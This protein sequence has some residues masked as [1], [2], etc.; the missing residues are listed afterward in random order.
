MPTYDPL[1]SGDTLT[2]LTQ[3]FTSKNVLGA[4]NSTLQ[5]N[6]GYTL[7]DGNGGANYTVTTN[8]VPGTITPAP[9]TVSTSAVNRVYDGT[10]NAAGSA[11]VTGG[12]L[13]GGDTLTGGTFAFVSKN[14]GTN[15][16]VN[17]SGVS[18]N[19][20]NGGANYVV[21][22][23]SNNTSNI[24]QANLNITGV[25]TANRTYDATTVASLGGSATV[26][27]FG[28]DVVSVSGTGTGSFAN[29]NV[30][31]A[32]AVT[33]TGFGLTGADAGNYLV[34][35]PTGLTA[36]ITQANLNIT[37]VTTANRTY[38]ATTV[39]SLGGS[40]T[41]TGFGADVV[42]VSGTGTGSFANKNVGSAKAVTVTG[43]GLT[44]AD[45]G[46]YLVVQPT[47][48]TADITPA[49]LTVSTN[50]VNR[51]Y[52]GTTNAAGSA[53]V[54]GGSL[55]GWRHAHGRHLRLCQQERGHQRHG[56]RQRRQRQRRQWRRQL[57]LDTG[58][59]RHQQHHRRTVGHHGCDGQQQGVRR[60]PDHGPERRRHRHRAGRRCGERQWRGYRQLCRQECGLGQGRHRLWLWPH[61]C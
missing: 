3:S 20:G 48:L 53:I 11:I 16:T 4:N 26:T 47:G 23:A 24:T 6:G 58:V 17:V 40:A 10:T 32:K 30:G 55:F 34:V 27:G 15:V 44:G 52:D 9:L 18:V 56:Q 7:N 49:S 60:H 33:V 42:S 54:T 50:A 38:D 8:T 41:V 5:V 36:D 59:Q 19:D 61:R 46:N 51:V 13:F 2:G 29:K 37:G 39:A 35:Q 14:V 22:Q 28:A 43:F 1:G 21:T 45:A 12:S 31:S 25:T 57:C